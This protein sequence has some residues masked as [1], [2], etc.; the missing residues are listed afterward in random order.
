MEKLRKIGISLLGVFIITI[1]MGLY[2][3]KSLQEFIG[4]MIFMAWFIVPI[5]LIIYGGKDEK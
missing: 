2:T 4:R 3:D 5:S 1:I